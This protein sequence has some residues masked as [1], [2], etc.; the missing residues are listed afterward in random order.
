MQAAPLLLVGTTPHSHSSQD[1]PAAQ[2]WPVDAVNWWHTCRQNVFHRLAGRVGWTPGRLPAHQESEKLKSDQFYST[3]IKLP[4]SFYM[5]WVVWVVGPNL[6]IPFC[7]QQCSGHVP[8]GPMFQSP[9]GRT[10]TQC[11][12]RQ[13][14][15]SSMSSS[16]S[17]LSSCLKP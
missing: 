17:C 9:T 15:K 8:S 3:Q 2:C 1:Q 16:M 11:C 12:N 7:A 10:G 14:V 6:E 13:M 5:S 4:W